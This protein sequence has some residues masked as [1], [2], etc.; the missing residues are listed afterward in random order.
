[1]EGKQYCCHQCYCNGRYINTAIQ[2]NTVKCYCRPISV[3]EY[4]VQCEC[5]TL[6][7]AVV[8]EDCGGA[9]RLHHSKENYN[10][11]LIKCCLCP[12]MTNSC[13]YKGFHE[14]TKK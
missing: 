11:Q 1:M 12:Y 2:H 3:T 10:M 13:C 9:G 14:V 6:D 7:Y 8:C 4:T 5:E